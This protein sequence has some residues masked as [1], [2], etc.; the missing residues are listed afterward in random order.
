MAHANGDVFNVRLKMDLLCEQCS[1][2]YV[3]SVHKTVGFYDVDD[4]Y[5]TAHFQAE[6]R[7]LDQI[8]TPCRLKIMSRALVP[9]FSACSIIPGQMEL[10][11]QRIIARARPMANKMGKDAGSLCAT[12]KMRALIPMDRASGMPRRSPIKVKLRKKTS[13]QI[14]AMNTAA[15]SVVYVVIGN[16]RPRSRTF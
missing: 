8:R 5:A 15:A 4:A 12:P 13:S 7:G 6:K 2:Q 3:I 9:L 1:S 10:V 14:G 11:R 16:I